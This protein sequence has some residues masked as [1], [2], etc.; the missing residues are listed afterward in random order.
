[1]PPCVREQTEFDVF[2]VPSPELNEHQVSSGELRLLSS[3]FPEVLKELM[4]QVEL[5]ED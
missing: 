1:M 3:F 5:I 2:I 4:V